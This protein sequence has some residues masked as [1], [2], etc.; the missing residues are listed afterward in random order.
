MAET[1]RTFDYHI[2]DWWPTFQNKDWI[3]VVGL[4]FWTER[5]RKKR[6]ESLEAYLPWKSPIFR[7]N[8]EQAIKDLV[9]LGTYDWPEPTNSAAR[10]RANLMGA[11][12]AF[13]VG[14][15]VMVIPTEVFIQG[16]EVVRAI[17]QLLQG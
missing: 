8:R 7:Q 4:V 15:H 5:I 17:A 6:G 12:N 11:R 9:S 16:P 10:M 2:R 1:E 3:P 14:Y 13:F